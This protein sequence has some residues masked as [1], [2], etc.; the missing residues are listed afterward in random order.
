ME[1]CPHYLLFDEGAYQSV[2]PYAKINPPIR[3]AADREAL[4]RGLADR[5]VDNVGSDHAPYTREEKERGWE[6]IFDAP[7]GT[8]GIEVLGASVLDMALRDRIS[9]ARAV[10]ALSSSPASTFGLTSKGSLEVGQDAD[11][12]VF[13]PRGGWTVN[14]EQLNTRSKQSA[15]LWEGREFRGKI[16]AVLL[17][18]NLA[19]QEGEV[20]IPQGGGRFIRPHADTAET[21]TVVEM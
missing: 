7:S 16:D 18:G 13:D 2:G 10:E 11:I 8:P 21:S 14:I 20:R 3:T 5:T 12:V 19:Y 1:T 9:L 15:K 6:R 4:I 17:R